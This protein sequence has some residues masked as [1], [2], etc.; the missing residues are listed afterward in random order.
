M[1]TKKTVGYTLYRVSVRLY[2]TLVL[3][4]GVGLLS[5]L[6]GLRIP[7]I[8]NVYSSFTWADAYIGLLVAVIALMVQ[9]HAAHT[10]NKQDKPTAP[11]ILTRQTN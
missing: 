10:E 4:F 9:F 11:S 7:I 8:A 1:D 2:Y 3:L 6:F 5:F